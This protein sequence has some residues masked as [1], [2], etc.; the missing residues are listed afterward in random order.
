M[1]ARKL[2]LVESKP[3]C[4]LKPVHQLVLEKK[5][6]E[7]REVL[8]N[9]DK[10]DTY[11]HRLL[12]QQ[13]LKH[14]LIA[15]ATVVTIASAGSLYFINYN[16]DNEPKSIIPQ[17]VDFNEDGVNDAYIIQHGGRR[18]PMYGVRTAAGDVMYIRDSEVARKASKKADHQLEDRIR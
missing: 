15:V 8:D 13:Y 14:G 17:E 5:E 10:I 1:S 16:R 3:G 2:R 7:H 18:V 4:K 11:I 6:K 9:W 12:R